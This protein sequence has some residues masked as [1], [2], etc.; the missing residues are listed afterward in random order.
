QTKTNQAGPT[1]ASAP[2][3]TTE[4][5]LKKKNPAPTAPRQDPPHETTPTRDW[6][7]L[8]TDD[9]PMDTDTPNFPP[10]VD[11]AAF[12]GEGDETDRD[13]FTTVKKGKGK[14][15]GAPPKPTFAQAAKQG[16]NRPMPKPP[17]VEAAKIASAMRTAGKNLT[18]IRYVA[19]SKSFNADF[20]RLTPRTIYTLVNGI[21]IRR[22]SHTRLLNANWNRK[23]RLVIQFPHATTISEIEEIIPDLIKT[24]EL[25][26][27]TSFDW[28]ARW[29][30][31]AISRVPTG[32]ESGIRYSSDEL[33]KALRVNPHVAML[34]IGQ[35][36]RWVT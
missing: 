17:V 25:P 12:I 27:D 20:K 34:E 31:V 15:H 35:A 3:K 36:P 1:R 2:K 6:D 30:K 16:V 14:A 9:V 26:E 33:L 11:A 23:N 5:E 32:I 13:R 22:N 19:S 4:V 29:S 10:I 7:Q 24:L 8:V 21:F 18:P 28:C